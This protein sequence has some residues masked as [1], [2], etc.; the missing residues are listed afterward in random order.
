MSRRAARVDD[1]HAEILAAVRSLGALV[2]DT[3]AVG[4]G[5]PDAIIGWRGRLIWIEIK[6]SARPPSA[7]KLTPSQCVF[8]AEWARINCPV[9]IVETVSDALRLL[10]AREGA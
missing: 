2:V 7:R 10:G 8:H 5:F 1:N 6:N 4:S 3:S 9:Q